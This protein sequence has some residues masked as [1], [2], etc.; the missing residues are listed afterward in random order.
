[1]KKT[2]K[3]AVA[4]ATG[5]ALLLGG[6]GTLA[7]WSDSKD[8]GGGAIDSGTLSLT[9]ETGQTCSAWTLDGGDAYTPG[10]TLVVPGDAITRSCT[11]TVN[12]TGEH[13]AADL[14]IESTSIT[15]GNDLADSLVPAA[16]YT[17]DGVAAVDG[18]QITAAN[19]GDVLVATISVTFDSAVTGLTAQNE[20]AA[21][22]DITISLQQHHA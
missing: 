5:G 21:L 4:A 14:G 2:T 18:D 8:V 7:F 6:A 1:M 10:T 19:D 22:E 3:G 9:Q 11:Y 20:S 16:T 15:G 12:A 13:L 17:L